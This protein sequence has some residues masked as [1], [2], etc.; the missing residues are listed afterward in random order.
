MFL[1]YG[2]EQIYPNSGPTS[3][4]TDVI[5]QGKGFVDE[6]GNT[7]RCRFGT[8]ANYAIVDAQILSFE[9]VACKAPSDYKLVPPAAFPEDV[10]FSIAFTS[11]EYDPWTE[12]SHKFRFYDQPVLIKCDPCEVDVGTMTEVL[13][14]A[15]ENTEFFEPVPINKPTEAEQ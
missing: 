15:D 1:P 12:T 7:A 8:P 2:I 9:R 6:E 5:V 10:P 11:D 3:G 14:W 13:V 4:V